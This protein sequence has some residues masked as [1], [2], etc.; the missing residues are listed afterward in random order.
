MQG[1]LFPFKKIAFTF[2]VSKISPGLESW[3]CSSVVAFGN[4]FKALNI[5]KQLRNILK[6]ISIYFQSWKTHEVPASATVF[7][8]QLMRQSL[9][10]DSS[11]IFW[12]GMSFRFL[13]GFLWLNDQL[14]LHVTAL[15]CCHLWGHS[16]I[17]PSSPFPSIPIFP[18]YRLLFLGGR[19]DTTGAESDR[20]I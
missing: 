11:V 13:C 5:F 4:I 19:R 16:L 7:I 17:S 2:R 14:V 12:H 18:V 9:A 10:W 6:N 3:V 8:T 15:L 20:L 1:I